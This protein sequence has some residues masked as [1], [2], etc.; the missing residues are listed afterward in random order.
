ME[1][2]AVCIKSAAF[3]IGGNSSVTINI[4]RASKGGGINLVENSVIAFKQNSTVLFS[5]NSATEYGGAVYSDGH[6][7][8]YF[9]G[10]SSVTFNDN[11]APQCGAVC[12][13]NNVTSKETSEVSLSK[14]TATYFTNTFSIQN[15]SIIFKE[16]LKLNLDIIKPKQKVQVVVLVVLILI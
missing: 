7:Y 15:L 4:N 10:K 6:S 9:E 2:G 14:K 5:G 12:S 16:N 11:K 13:F 3:I 8:I 1:G